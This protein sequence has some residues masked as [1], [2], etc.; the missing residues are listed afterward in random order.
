[1][2]F[3]YANGAG[4]KA[5]R[6]RRPRQLRQFRHPF[7]RDHAAGQQ[8]AQDRRRTAGRAG[9]S[10]AI[11]DYYSS[12]MDEAAIETKGASPWPTLS[13]SGNLQPPRTRRGPRQTVRADVDVLNS[14]NLYTPHLFGVWVAQ[15]LNDPKRYS[16]FLLQGGL[17]MPDREYY[18]SNSQAMAAIR[19]KYQAHIA[20]I[21]GLAG[22]DHP[23]DRAAR[24]FELERRMAEVH[25]TRAASEQIAAGNN[26]WARSQFDAR[27]PDLDWRTFFAAAGL[28][29]QNDFVVWQPSALIGLAKLTADLPLE[30]WKDY[31][32]FH[33]VEDAAPYLSK[34]F[35]EESF[36][37]N[38]HILFGIPELRPR[39][40][41][42]VAVCD[43]ALGDAA[44]SSRRSTSPR[45]EKARRRHG[46]F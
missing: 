27:A 45:R 39:W 19:P 21:L 14:T 36:A 26:H 13:T 10:A 4:S 18:L 44:A 38:G 40:K 12:F 8:A 2:I 37:F 30:T 24:I 5:P 22:V 9:T 25:W 11:S 42:A 43:A 15:D 3:A 23:A 46:A 1:M 28:A 31:L 17:G 34:A 41:R 29:G 35:V 16:P 33:A 7:R 6:F 20:S 32:K